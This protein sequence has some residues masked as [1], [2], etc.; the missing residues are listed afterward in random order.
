MNSIDGTV[1]YRFNEEGEDYCVCCD[2]PHVYARSVEG[3]AGSGI[4]WIHEQLHKVPDGSRV[5]L[6]LSIVA[7]DE[8]TS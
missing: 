6:T 8:V 5:R 4:G 7:D 3:I 1:R 2:G